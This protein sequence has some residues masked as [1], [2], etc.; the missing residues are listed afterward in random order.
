MYTAQITKERI[1]GLCKIQKISMEQMLSELNLG[2]NAVRQITDTKGMSSVSLYKI[3][4]Y[5]NVSVDYLLGRTDNPEISMNNSIKIGDNSVNNN[6][7]VNISTA[8]NSEITEIADM[9][10]GLSLVQRSK[11]VV[12]IDEMKK[13]N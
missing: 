4:D 1:K 3:A 11:I 5:L 6:G 13:E 12:M 2:V 10:K 9:M 7:D 8:S